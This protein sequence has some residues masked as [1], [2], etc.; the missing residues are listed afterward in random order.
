[1]AVTANTNETYN[2]STIKEN[3]QDALV[4][5]SPT[6]TPFMSAIGTK[7]VSNTYFEWATIDLAAASS[8]NRVAE[9]EKHSGQRR[10]NERYSFG[11]LR[12]DF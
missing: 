11:Q 2:V 7:S 10:T 8:T 1:M 3:I 12:S 9:G 5:I 4:S 6:E